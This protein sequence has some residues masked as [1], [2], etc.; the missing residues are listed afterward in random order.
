MRTCS[1]ARSACRPNPIEA[2]GAMIERLRAGR[3]RTHRPR[4]PRGRRR[5]PLVHLL[6]GLRPRR[7]DRREPSSASAR[8]VP[9]QRRRCSCAPACANSCEPTAGT[10]RSPSTRPDARAVEGVFMAIVTNTTPWTYFGDRPLEPTPDASFDT[11]LDVFALRRLGTLS[12]ATNLRRLLVG[13]P[14][15]RG[16]H[17]VVASRS[18]RADAARP[19]GRAGRGRRRVPRRA[20]RLHLVVGA[21]GDLRH[22]LT[23]RLETGHRLNRARLGDAAARLMWRIP[24]SEIAELTNLPNRPAASLAKRSAAWFSRGRGT[25][26]TPRFPG[27]GS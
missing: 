4:R 16:R 8:R 27:R 17:V 1:P 20:H 26:T 15:P 25:R 11:G 14:T 21:G 24:Q 2:T 6:R 9:R 13:G 19:A 22:R 18:G 12:T 7:R 3:E 10:P 23:G 5:A